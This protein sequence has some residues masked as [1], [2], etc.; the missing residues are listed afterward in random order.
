MAELAGK[1]RPQFR[2]IHVTQILAYRLPPAGVVSILHRISGAL[3]F[4]IGIPFALY[5]FQ[6]SVTSEISFESYRAIVS[7]WFAKLVLLALIWAIV[8]HALAGLRH[9][10]TDAHFWLDLAPARVSAI[11]VLVA[12]V[13]LT[14]VLGLRL[15]GVF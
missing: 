8:H 4:L 2:N 11:A 1:S 13:L 12:S 5:L 14:A 15:F 9:L 3:L 10:F 7:H 6:L